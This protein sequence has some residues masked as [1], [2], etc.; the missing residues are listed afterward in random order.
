MLSSPRWPSRILTFRWQHC[1][2]TRHTCKQKYM[3]TKRKTVKDSGAQRSSFSLFFSRIFAIAQ[4]CCAYV[5]IVTKV[6]GVHRHSFC[7]YT[8]VASMF[9]CSISSLYTVYASIFIHIYLF[10]LYLAWKIL[11]RISLPVLLL[12]IGLSLS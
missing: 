1:P 8:S 11:L 10:S 3:K 4:F 12:Y 5:A 2:A 9:K 6:Y 7:C